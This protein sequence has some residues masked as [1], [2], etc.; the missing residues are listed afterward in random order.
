MT[1]AVY[2]KPDCPD[3][4]RVRAGFGAAAI[5]YDFFDVIASADAAATAARIS[6][7]ARTPVLVLPDRSHL[8][9]PDDDVIAHS[10][11]DLSGASTG[12]VGARR[13]GRGLA[14]IG[15]IPTSSPENRM[16]ASLAPTLVQVR[17]LLLD[18]AREGDASVAIDIRALDGADI[19]TSVTVDLLRGLVQSYTLEAGPDAP[20]VNICVSSPGQDEDRAVTWGYLDD[21]EGTMARGATIDLREDQR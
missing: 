12:S 15:V 17:R 10:V 6:R 9:E 16:S 20:A 3:Y 11:A 5:A 7:G 8:V 4:A 19:A 2:G 13:Y 14:I 18:T 21:A 1:V